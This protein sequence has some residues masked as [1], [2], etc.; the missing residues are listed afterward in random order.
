LIQ[1]HGVPVNSRSRDVRR[2]SAPR[3]RRVLVV[4]TLFLLAPHVEAHHSHLLL[5]AL[6]AAPA[7]SEPQPP[8]GPDAIPA[9]PG[10][11]DA[12]VVK[13]WDKS[14]FGRNWKP[15]ACTLWNEQGFTSLVTI[16]ARFQFLSG[17]E[18]LLQQIGAISKLAGTQYWSTTHKQWRILITDAYALAG[19]QP[20][21]RRPD[22]TLDELKPGKPFYFEQVDNLSG[23][24]TYRMNIL[25]A[26]ANRVVFEV[27][28]VSTVRYHFIPVFHP[29]E[30]QSIYFFDRESDKI[31]RYYSILREGKNASRLVAG[32]EASSVNRA[33]A[34]YRHMVGIPS[35]QE[36]PAAR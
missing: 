29:S 7:A 15:P 1:I 27:E 34:L 32:N 2:L 22:F 28:N 24:T 35:N 30:L 31:W 18:G 6:P 20:D 5:L 9:Y 3:L 25:E 16:S 33:V 17:A 26:S 8:C 23:K 11:G 14:D 4:S 19:S 13:S 10:L 21:Q 36:P 12:A